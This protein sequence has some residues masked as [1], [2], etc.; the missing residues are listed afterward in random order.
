M[1]VRAVVSWQEWVKYLGVLMK[2][3]TWIFQIYLLPLMLPSGLTLPVSCLLKCLPKAGKN[4]F[5]LRWASALLCSPPSDSDTVWCLRSYYR[6]PQKTPG[7]QVPSGE[8]GS[9]RGS[10]QST[11]VLKV[12][13]C[14]CR[15]LAFWH[16]RVL[17]VKILQSGVSKEWIEGQDP[18]D[19]YGMCLGWLFG[20]LV[21][22]ILGSVKFPTPPLKSQI[23][24]E[25]CN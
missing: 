23:I 10:W 22:D 14:T 18:W 4:D 2:G 16:S 5:L 6:P 3:V 12:P 1:Q 24:I 17:G 21:L 19:M 7:C 20:T 15:L 9:W 11:T 13:S 25:K 8:N